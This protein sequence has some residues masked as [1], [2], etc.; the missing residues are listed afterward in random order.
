MPLLERFR[1]DRVVIGSFAHAPGEAPTEVS[2]WTRVTVAFT[3]HGTWQVATRRG[4]GEITPATVLVSAAHAEHEYRHSDGMDDRV[5][6]V[7]YRGDPDPGPTLVVPHVAGLRSLRRSLVRELAAGEL[8][9][10]GEVD[11]LCLALLEL[12]REPPDRG[13]RLSWRAATV[14]ER[15]RASACAQY[16]DLE[17][18]LVAEA[19]ALG[20]TRTRLIHAFRDAFGVTPHRFLVELRTTHAARLLTETRLPVTDI[21]F[22]SGFGSMSRFHAAFHSAYGRTPSQHRERYG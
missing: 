4:G 18:D 6:S 12:S 5:L 11:E 8:A 22:S 10:P 20:M 15:L 7:I 21:C 2:W 3:S 19:A 17:F 1:T 13:P 9:D 14:V 16:T